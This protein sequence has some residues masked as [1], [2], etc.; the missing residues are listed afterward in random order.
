MKEKLSIEE[1]HKLISLMREGFSYLSKLKEK[2]PVGKHI[3]YFK[4]P[5]TLSESIAIHLLRRQQ[6]LPAL[7]DMT[8]EH[9]NKEADIVAKNGDDIVNIE[10]K[11]TAESAFQNLGKKDIQ[12]D[13]II[14]LHFGAYFK[15]VEQTQISAYIITKPE[16][17]FKEPGKINLSKLK[18][19]VSDVET[20]DIDIS[21]L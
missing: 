2:D 11:A 9:N 5:S 12:A 8:F 17:Y 4:V 20:V 21:K 19:M 14:W 16:L 15:D 18:E 13:Y 10:I 1:I 3:N 6:I 7:S